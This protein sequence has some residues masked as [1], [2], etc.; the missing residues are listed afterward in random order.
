MF[1][2]FAS[3][4]QSYSEELTRQNTDKSTA[5][6]DDEEDETNLKEFKVIIPYSTRILSYFVRKLLKS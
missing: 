2:G 3:R 6:N 4:T 1:Q 5:D